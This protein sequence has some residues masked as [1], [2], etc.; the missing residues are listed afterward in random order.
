MVAKEISNIKKAGKN[1]RNGLDGK[2]G[3][4]IDEN[5]EHNLAPKL[6]KTKR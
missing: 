2:G 5:L 6:L 3:F 4:N 1:S